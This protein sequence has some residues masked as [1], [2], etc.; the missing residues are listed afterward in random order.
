MKKILSIALAVVML[1]SVFVLVAC[2]DKD[3]SATEDGTINYAKLDYAKYITLSASDYKGVTV[4]V[5]VAPE[6]DDDDVNEYIE[7]IR[8]QLA[9]S[10]TLTDVAI[11][12]GDTVS[13]Y[14][15]EF[16]FVY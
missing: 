16:D 3:D 4:K 10:E 11:E 1:C 6:I 5:D 9:D 8:E 12:E 15:F 14:D 7:Y 13:I 2:G